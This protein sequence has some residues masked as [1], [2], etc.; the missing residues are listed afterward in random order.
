MPW[1]RGM[2]VS[3]GVGAALAVGFWFLGPDQGDD[4]FDL[5]HRLVLV[6][7][8]VSTPLAL[9]L[10]GEPA[11]PSRWAWLPKVVM[12][13]QPV[14]ALAA[15]AS[16]ALPQG[17]PLAGALAAPWVLVSGLIAAWGLARLWGRGL[18]NPLARPLEELC[19]VAGMLYLPVGA[20]WL[21]ASR[22]GLELMGFPL[23]IVTLTALHFHFAGLAA[24]IL[25]GL[26]GRALAA[27][28]S[29][30]TG[31]AWGLY[32]V[33]AWSMIFNPILIALGITVSPLLEVVCAVGLAV[34]LL[35]LSGLMMGRL[36]PRAKGLLAPILLA[37]SGLSLVLT[38]LLAAL[39]AV[40]EFLEQGW[41]SISAMAHSHGWIN[42]VGFALCGLLAWA[43]DPPPT[44]DEPTT[45]SP[46]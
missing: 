20:S 37:V 8:L 38:M 23:V 5:L 33:S 14:G 27:Q 40:G 31:V 1:V 34:G 44:R 17:S 4:L 46:R 18:G 9:S 22:L 3:A 13:A 15:L 45:D 24:P 25:T 16:M 42:I 11:L 35:G 12:A 29:G 7:P 10:L 36:A 39:Y 28:P 30:P 6:G 43:L 21:V 19:V 26:A 41:I 32:R 2:R